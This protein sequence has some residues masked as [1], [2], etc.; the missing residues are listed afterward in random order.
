MNSRRMTLIPDRELRDE[1]PDHPDPNPE[2]LSRS[3]HRSREGQEM[4]AFFEDLQYDKPEP[5]SKGENP[6]QNLEQH[7]ID[8]RMSNEEQLSEDMNLLNE[9][10]Q[11]DPE[12]NPE[13]SLK[14]GW[15]TKL[16]PAG[17][18]TTSRKKRKKLQ[19]P[20]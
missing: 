2:L 18:Q 4:Q 20:V 13:R 11:P 6:V 1:Q 10:P 7:S 9:T 3:E 17:L 5:W 8:E 16:W 12:G 15:R 19:I 14:D